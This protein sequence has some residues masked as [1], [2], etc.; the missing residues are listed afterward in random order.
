A[1][2]CCLQ[3]LFNSCYFGAEQH[4][5]WFEV[6]EEIPSGPTT[7]LMMETARRHSMVLI[8]PIYERKM[9]G[10]LYN[11]AP[12]ISQVHPGFWEKFYFRP[13]DGGYP[14]FD[15]PFGKI[16]LYVCY[17]RHFP[18]GARALGL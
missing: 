17:D 9:Q 12:I 15:T 7:R 14:V 6:A 13:G 10:L 2:V 18:E 5:R 8:A 3:E 11:S 1:Q 4:E 16:G